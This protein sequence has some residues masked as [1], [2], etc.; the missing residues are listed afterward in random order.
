MKDNSVSSGI[1]N[2]KP[3]S[4]H[5]KMSQKLFIKLFLLVISLSVLMRAYY[6]LRYNFFV[7]DSDSISI[8]KTILSI[9]LEGTIHPDFGLIYSNGFGYQLYSLTVSLLSNVSV[10]YYQLCLRPL[11]GTVTIIVSYL[12][13]STHLKDR[14]IVLLSILLLLLS[15]IILFETTRA[16]HM[17]MDISFLLLSFYL[18]KKYLDD[19]NIQ[20][21]FL[22]IPVLISLNITNIFMGL[23]I[24]IGLVVTI[25][26]RT[27][28]KNY[29]ASKI[30]REKSKTN[31]RPNNI[32]ILLIFL[33]CLFV[34]IYT[35]PIMFNTV[36]HVLK[37]VISLS[38]SLSSMSTPT[39]Y[40]YVASAW[41][42]P[43][44][45]WTTIVLYNITILPLSL[46]LFTN[47]LYN[48]FVKKSPI[49]TVEMAVI[50]V[51]GILGFL[52]VVAILVDLIGAGG[53]GSNLQLRITNIIIPFSI[54]LIGYYI[55]S[56][57]FSCISKLFKS[58]YIIILL[59]IFTIGSLFYITADPLVSNS[60][61]YFNSDEKN[62]L[63]WLDGQ[64]DRE[65]IVWE[66]DAFVTGSRYSG[67]Y[68][69][70]MPIRSDRKLVFAPAS[71]NPKYYLSSKIT[72]DHYRDQKV[73]EPSFY[74]FDNIYS[75]D[76]VS[77]YSSM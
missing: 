20:W 23:I 10:L 62:A 45:Y 61:R 73:S 49:S 35:H 75:N 1:S 43:L 38:S 19:N 59:I 63:L 16:S 4:H 68:S 5:S 39:A 67:T 51:F 70:F 31:I 52:V 25:I 60:W 58:K 7:L 47:S 27:Y 21:L 74:K 18:L 72:S 40:T 44:F 37:T 64:L 57:S 26:I 32:L 56:N 13:F 65:T 50:S 9:E 28:S 22:L 53:I 14:K 55:H 2:T 6:M 11:L 77:I 24:N 46:I 30:T 3:N 42:S 76:D 54:L 15:P 36:V 17:F 71:M 41:K 29:F 69:L 48:Y 12:F 8:T 66:G 33:I 34:T